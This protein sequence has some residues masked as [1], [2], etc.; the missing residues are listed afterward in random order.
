M[1]A[2][3]ARLRLELP[4]SG[5]ITDPEA[6]TPVVVAR[7][8]KGDLV[9]VKRDDAFVLNGVRGS[10]ARAGRILAAGAAGLVSAGNRHST[11]VSRTARLAEAAGIPCR[12]WTAKSKGYTVQELD[13]I[14]H[15]AEIVKGPVT[16]LAPLQGKAREDAQAR[17][18]RF[19]ELGLASP[20]YIAVNRAQAAN[21]PKQ[22]RRVVV[23]VGSGT[24]LAAILHGLDD[25]GL[26]I[27]VLGVCVGKDPRP[28][29]ARLAPRGWEQRVRLVHS[30]LRYEQRVFADSMDGIPMDPYYEGKLVEH[31]Q[32]DDCIYLL[33]RR[34]DDVAAAEG[35]EPEPEPELPS[36]TPPEVTTMPERTTAATI[37]EPID[38]LRQDPHNPRIIGQD[39]LSG[40]GT[41]MHEFGDLS[42]I[43]WN[44]QLNVLVAGHQRVNRLKAAG[45]ATWERFSADYG[46]IVHPLTGEQFPVR[47][48]RWDANKTRLANL[49]ANNPHIAGD[50]TPEALSQLKQLEEQAL[51]E[52]LLLDAL[53]EHLTD[54]LTPDLGRAGGE[55]GQGSGAGSLAERF[56]VPPVSVL[57]A[58]Q[59]YWRERKRSWLSMGIQSELGRGDELTFAG[60]GGVVGEEIEKLGRTSIFDPVLAEIAYRW[61]CPP[62]GLVLDPFAGGSV[63]GIVAGMTGRRYHGIDLSAAQVEANRKQ[64]EAMFEPGSPAVPGWFV[65]DSRTM[66]GVHPAEAD[67]VFSCPPYGDLEQYSE[68]PAD[69]SN[70]SEADFIEA[71][72]QVIA[73][74]CARLKPDRFAVFVVG[75]YRRPDSYYVDLVG[76]TVDAFAR[77]GAQLYNE[78]V[79]VTPMGSARLRA[80]HTFTRSL[81]LVRCHQNVLVFCKG[82]YTEAVRAVGPVEAGELPTDDE[83]DAEGG[84]A[85]GDALPF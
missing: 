10:K 21:I 28:V 44:E 77:A 9:W 81:K 39:A 48:V 4:R 1:T 80:S 30:K 73:C 14:S 82:K 58:R 20:E 70:M 12:V 61:F 38:T 66:E 33:A 22:A 85:P 72:R 37:T 25:A 51:F 75:N 67:L 34:S 11:M 45:A 59:G 16:Y 49:A 65:G 79:L 13:A 7:I 63:R 62:G 3:P 56:V 8:P 53:Q 52:G 68:D 55:D 78:A 71:Y 74:A 2:V 69:L 27:P 36:P 40:L 29:L 47:I 23:A 24:G 6:L 35:P 15:G 5:D 32:E 26:D 43:V 54:E 46:V 18:W 83:A 19:L 31:A 76:I 50:F 84:K 41:S 17:G 57:D 64:A 42:G 60:G